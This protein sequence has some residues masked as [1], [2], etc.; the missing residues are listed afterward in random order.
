[1][2]QCAEKVPQGV[3]GSQVET[4]LS[5]PHRRCGTANLL[6]RTLKSC[7]VEDDPEIWGPIVRALVKAAGDTRDSRGAARCASVLATLRAQNIDVLKYLDKNDRLD[8]GKPTESVSVF[9]AEFD[10]RG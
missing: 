2:E 9:R 8:D 4:D 6:E 1:M 10:R 3:G 7:R 5:D